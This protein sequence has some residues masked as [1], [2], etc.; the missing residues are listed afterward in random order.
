MSNY[1]K[2]A[3]AH[4]GW[5]CFPIAIRR[6]GTK[7]EKRPLIKGWQSITCTTPEDDPR[8]ASANGF[9]ILMLGT[10]ALDID[11]H[12]DEGVMAEAEAWFNRH[13]LSSRTRAHRTPSGITIK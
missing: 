2:E 9:G 8:W 5:T 10:Y 6:N 11:A 1:A 4:P 12:K 3:H 13:G 7:F